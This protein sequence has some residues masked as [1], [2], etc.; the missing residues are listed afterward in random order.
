MV[1]R[2]MLHDRARARGVTHRGDTANRSGTR[3]Q[4]Y[5]ATIVQAVPESTECALPFMPFSPSRN[6]NIA[7]SFLDQGLPCFL[8]LMAS[9]IPVFDVS[10]KVLRSKSAVTA[11]EISSETQANALR[12][13][14][15]G[16]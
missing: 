10:H 1:L 11:L 3:K 8:T 15:S 4:N 12:R 16:F 5:A 9:Q 2:F 13:R 7:F 6:S 14:F